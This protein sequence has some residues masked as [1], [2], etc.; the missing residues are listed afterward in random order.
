LRPAL[1]Y[2]GRSHL[3]AGNSLPRAMTPTRSSFSP[4]PCCCRCRL[5]RPCSCGTGRSWRYCR[6]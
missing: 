2:D 4:T 5:C 6:R 1:R 3:R